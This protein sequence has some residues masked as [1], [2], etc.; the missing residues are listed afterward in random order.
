MMLHALNSLCVCV[1]VCVCV[2][3]CLGVRIC[4]RADLSIPY[5]VDNREELLW[6]VGSI[7]GKGGD[8]QSYKCGGWDWIG[9]GR[10]GIE[11]LRSPSRLIRTFR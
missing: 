4:A 10:G 5:W 1:C 6:C 9:S 11:V 7:G 8:D 3:A 2:C